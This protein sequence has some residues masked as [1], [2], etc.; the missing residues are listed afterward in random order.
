MPDFCAYTI[1]IRGVGWRSVFVGLSR[2]GRVGVV[3]GTR[4]TSRTS[5]FARACMVSRTLRTSRSRTTKIFESIRLGPFKTRGRGGM[6]SRFGSSKIKFGL[7]MWL[8]F[9]S[10]GLF[11]IIIG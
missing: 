6:G 10:G 4:E 2:A 8:I 3:S 11:L 5:W 1:F 7:G 9:R